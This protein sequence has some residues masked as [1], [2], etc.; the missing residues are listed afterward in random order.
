M[1]L[2]APSAASWF[3]GTINAAKIQT[4]L[5]D[6]INAGS[7]G[8]WG[9]ANSATAVTLATVSTDYASS[10]TVTF[11]LPVQRRVLIIGSAVYMIATVTAGGF[12]AQAAYSAGSSAN[13]ASMTKL[14]RAAR[15]YNNCGLAGNINGAVTGTT[16]G[17]VVLTAGTYTA[18]LACARTVGGS[19][20]DTALNFEI[21]VLDCGP[22]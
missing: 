7:W 20:T 22:S 21:A 12:W 14:S 16:L 10:A 9:E 1:T 3:T 2:P 4:N 13:T 11:T 15:Q 18:F 17:S 6:P 5:T 19:A 8:L